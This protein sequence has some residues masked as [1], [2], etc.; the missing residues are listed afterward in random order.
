M[1]D[2]HRQDD[3]EKIIVSGAFYQFCTTVERNPTCK[4]TADACQHGP[5]DVLA[6]RWAIA[7]E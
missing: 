6:A 4:C 2:G 5:F 7:P 1:S 3:K